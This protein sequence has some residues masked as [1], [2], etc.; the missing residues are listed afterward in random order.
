MLSS[1]IISY[2]KCALSERGKIRKI[3]RDTSIPVDWLYKVANGNIPNP[4]A[5][6]IEQLGL[7]IMAQ[8][9]QAAG[10]LKCATVT[11]EVA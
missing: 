7:Y 3:H 11:S 10:A 9:E 2:L 4:Q 6:R 5:R 1:E 8:R